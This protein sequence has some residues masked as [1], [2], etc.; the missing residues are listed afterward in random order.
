M[1]S[2][3]IRPPVLWVPSLVSPIID[4]PGVGLNQNLNG[5]R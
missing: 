1:S 3:T 5:A 4:R 2:L